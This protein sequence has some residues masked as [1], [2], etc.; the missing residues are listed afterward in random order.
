MSGSRQY[1]DILMGYRE[2]GPERN[3]T[4]MRY[5]GRCVSC[6]CRVHVVPS[7]FDI[8][9]SSNCDAAL[10]CDVCY[11]LHGEDLERAMSRG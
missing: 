6:G 2:S 8:L 7:G 5:A 3:I 1:D 11:H 9:K 4:M 10:I